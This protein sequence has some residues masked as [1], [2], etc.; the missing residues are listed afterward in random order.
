MNVLVVSDL[1]DSL[2]ALSK[3]KEAVVGDN[4]DVVISLGDF[5]S[6]FTLIELLKI[7]PR[8]VGVFGNNDGDV[9][10]LKSVVPRLTEQPLEESLEGWSSLLLHGFKSPQLTEKIVRSLCASGYYDL[11]LYGHTHKFKVDS[12]ESCLA[13]NPGT[14]SGYLASVRSYGALT[15][16]G[17]EAVARV[18]D[19]DTG[20]ELVRASLR[21]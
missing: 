18:I 19:L 16:T 1:H 9:D 2:G 4:Y 7:V 8:V 6:P 3:L 11:I 14:L 17:S 15:L 20:L 13:L 10:L 21:K 12:F 5:T